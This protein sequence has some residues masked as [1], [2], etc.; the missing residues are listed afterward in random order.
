M[1]NV[2]LR[3]NARED[4][5]NIFAWLERESPR[6]AD[7]F[8]DMI[9]SKLD[10]L[11]EYP[12]IGHLREERELANLKL[13]SHAAGRYLIFYRVVPNGVDIIRVLHGSMD[14]EG[15]DNW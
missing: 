10:L 15:I 12:E 8:G 2:T 13:R 3:P 14:I 5:L 4:L 1:P 6:V 9:R 11:A 7:E